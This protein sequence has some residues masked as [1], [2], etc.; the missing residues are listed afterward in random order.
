MN[1]QFEFSGDEQLFISINFIKRRK[2]VVNLF[3]IDK[4][5]ELSYVCCLLIEVFFINYM[6]KDK[7]VIFEG[8][9]DYWFVRMNY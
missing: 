6:Q 8:V 7:L 4:N 5:Y 2:G 9:M 3:I 1:F